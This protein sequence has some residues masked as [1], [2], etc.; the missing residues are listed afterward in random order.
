MAI[1]RRYR[2]YCVSRI[3]ILFLTLFST[4][5]TI[6]FIHKYF[7]TILFQQRNEIDRIYFIDQTDLD[8]AQIKVTRNVHLLSKEYFNTTYLT[9]RYPKLMIDN[10]EI[11]K[12]LEPVTNG[13]PE[14]EKAINWVYVENGL[15]N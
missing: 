11:W 9:C 6:T 12:H 10:E 14:C 5:S 2:R 8:D 3:S 1:Y 15:L 7:S 4:I 13:K